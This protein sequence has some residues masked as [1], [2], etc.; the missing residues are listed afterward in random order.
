MMAAPSA[1]PR[2]RG[3]HGSECA[4]IVLAL[5]AYAL[6][7]GSFWLIVNPTEAILFSSATTLAHILMIAIP[8]AGCKLPAKSAT[9]A[10]CAV[11]LLIINGAFIVGP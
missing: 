3:T 10:T 4:A 6:L 9:L 8:F 1:L 7:R 2:F 11:L 5:L